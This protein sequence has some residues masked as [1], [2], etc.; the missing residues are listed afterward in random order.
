MKMRQKKSG[1]FSEFQ[2]SNITINASPQKF[3]HFVRVVP[4]LG[5][6]FNRRKHREAPS[7]LRFIFPS[8]LPVFHFLLQNNQVCFPSLDS[9]YSR[10]HSNPVRADV[11]PLTLLKQ[12]EVLAILLPSSAQQDPLLTFPSN[13]NFV[14]HP[15]CLS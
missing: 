2:I 12:Q 11:T 4:H 10:L 9:I 1:I 8:H 15:Q 14:S 13:A 5:F 3:W 7:A 6:H